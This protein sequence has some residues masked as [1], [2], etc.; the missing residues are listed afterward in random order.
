MNV[1]DNNN[2]LLETVTTIDICVNKHLC[3][4][5]KRFTQLYFKQK[6]KHFYHSQFWEVNGED[7]GQG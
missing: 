5:I 2:K 6:K 4:W 3:E 1:T 7:M